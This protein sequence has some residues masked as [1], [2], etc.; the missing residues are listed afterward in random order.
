MSSGAATLPLGDIHDFSSEEAQQLLS[1]KFVVILGDSN[2]RTIYKDF[3]KFLQ[4]EETLMLPQLQG[5]GEESFAND[6]RVEFKGLHNKDTFC[7]VRQYR[8]EHHLVRFYFITRVFSNYMESI[9]NDFKVGLV[10]DVLIMNSCLWDLN[11]YHDRAAADPIRKAL[12]EYRQNLG[13]LFERLSDIL[14]PGCLIIWNTAMPIRNAHGPIFQDSKQSTPRDVI[15]ANFY[16]ASLAL[17]YRFD[18][19]D[20]HYAVRFLEDHHHSDG[21]HWSSWV[22]RCVTKLLLTHMAGA[23][24]VQLERRRPQP[25]P[26]RNMDSVNAPRQKIL[27]STPK[28]YPPAPVHR[29]N[30]GH[31]HPDT[32][33]YSNGS[34]NGYGQWCP[35]QEDQYANTGYRQEPQSQFDWPNPGNNPNFQRNG[36]YNNGLVAGWQGN[37]AHPNWNSLGDDSGFG[38]NSSYGHEFLEEHPCPQGPQRHPNWTNFGNGS[39]SSLNGSYGH[40]FAEGPGLQ[41]HP[42]WHSSG[43]GSS[44]GHNDSYGHEFLEEHPCPQGP[45]R[46]PNWTNFGN[47][48]GSSLN[49]SYGHQF[50]E[51]PG[52][53][54]HP[55]WHSSGN[56]SSLGHNDSYGHGFDGDRPYLQGHQ[57]HPH[58][59]FHHNNSYAFTGEQHYDPQPRCSWPSPG[60]DSGFPLNGNFFYRFLSE[61][62]CRNGHLLQHPGQL[63]PGNDPSFQED[64]GFHEE[65]LGDYERDHLPHRRPLPQLENYIPPNGWCPEGYGDPQRGPPNMAEMHQ[66]F[67]PPPLPPPGPFL[68]PYGSP[69]EPRK[70][71]LVNCQPSQKNV[72]NKKHRKGSRKT[73]GSRKS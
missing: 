4:T 5:K 46:H 32:M 56:G 47:G 19:L 11:K 29:G 13:K 24:G 33:N 71:F 21:V 6:R 73:R 69:R 61:P 42:E 59:G 27:T 36:N 43:N 64:V 10:P 54:R 60:N 34:V 25:G 66:S 55:E 67:L 28:G 58:D 39:G 62:P 48:S 31:F 44:L 63:R 23:W 30:R 14:P 52:P 3:I 37:Q 72:P 18:V 16:S 7:E 1:N 70:R 51:G 53:Q 22:H 49:G 65:N 8:T 12:L 26:E 2:Y 57:R 68:S 50:A 45:Q 17:C 20:L 15:E 41:R 35:G 40:Q 9:L 38:H